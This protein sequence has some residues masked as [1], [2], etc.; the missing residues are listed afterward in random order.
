MGWGFYP[1]GLLEVLRWMRKYDKPVI[2]T[3]N[4]TAE[5][6][7]RARARF[8]VEHLK[9]VAR[10]IAEGIPVAGYLY[11]SLLDNFE[12]DRGFAPRFGLVEVDGKTLE[13]RIRPSA[14]VFKEI[15]ETGR[16]K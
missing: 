6:D 2:I 4:G 8:I 5:T 13:R 9:S 10:A 12:W 7:D 14:Y 11:W 15:I 3:E 1:D 16:I